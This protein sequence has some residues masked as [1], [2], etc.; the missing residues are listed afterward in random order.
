MI[1]SFLDS[2]HHGLLRRYRENMMLRKKLVLTILIAISAVL[3][4]TA[5]G[6]AAPS[7]TGGN[8]VYLPVVLHPLQYWIKHFGDDSRYINETANAAFSTQDGGL[9]ILI[10]QGSSP[11]GDSQDDFVIVKTTADGS[12]LWQKGLGSFDVPDFHLNGQETSDGSLIFSGISNQAGNNGA[13]VFK[14]NAAGDIQWQRNFG[15]ENF[16]YASAIEQTADG[17]YIF[18][19]YTASYGYG[20]TDMWL[21]KLDPNGNT[22]WQKTVGLSAFQFGS[23]LHQT[24]DG[25]YIVTG[26]AATGS[27]IYD[28]WVVKFT[29][30]GSVSWQKRYGGS[31]QDKSLLRGRSGP[32]AQLPTDGRACHQPCRPDTP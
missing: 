27:S 6:G 16:D 28:A 8:L 32:H 31:E 9:I 30:N 12:I 14:T 5:V 11:T 7:S 22:L 20:F 13:Q 18:T 10:E 4:L 25:G 15:G 1:E 24:S 26:Q 19:G 23:A 29:A 21:V 2:V 17:G 3:L